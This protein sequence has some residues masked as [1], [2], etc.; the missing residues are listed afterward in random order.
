VIYRTRDAFLK[1]EK[2]P[3]FNYDPGNC[4]IFSRDIKS[5]FKE[6]HNMC[7][8]FPLL[9]NGISISSVEALYQACKFPQNK[10]MQRRIIKAE[11]A[12]EA[13]EISKECDQ[14]LI[15]ADWLDVQVLIM[16]WCERVKLF[17]NWDEFSKLLLSLEDLEIVLESLKKDFFWSAIRVIREGCPDFL[18]GSNFNGRIL[19]ELRDN[20]KIGVDKISQNFSI[21]PPPPVR[22]FL[23]LGEKIR[24]IKRS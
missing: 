13:K 6:L 15:R 12:F 18:V 5:Q 17:Q 11:Y 14:N 7:E 1:S 2:N 20:L 8:G 16:E 24:V 22:D 3:I 21:L 4:I 19:T 9:V 10:E 23:L